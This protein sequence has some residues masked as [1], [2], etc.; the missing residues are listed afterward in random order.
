MTEPSYLTATRAGYDSFAAEYAEA[1]ADELGE[2]PFQLAMLAEFAERV[3]SAGAGPVADIGCGPGRVSAHLA[4]LG[5]DVFGLDLSSEMIAL[6][7]RT[8]PGLRFDVGA[9]PDLDLADA[10]LG[11]VL[12]WYSVIHLPPELLPAAFAEF[13]RVLVPG[14]HLLLAFQVGD[15]PL[16]VSEAFGHEVALDFHRLRPERVSD[17]LEDAGFRVDARLVRGPHDP[18]TSETRLTERMP[19]AYILASAPA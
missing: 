2:K 15:E 6:A 10:S 1:A 9:M 8:Y 16:H 11:G 17:L 3:R 19:Q 7:R 4:S 12:A 5:V 14:G 18:G 13:R